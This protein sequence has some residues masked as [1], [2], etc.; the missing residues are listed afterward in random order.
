MLKTNENIKLGESL[1]IFFVR[2]KIDQEKISVAD[3]SDI[4][5]YIEVDGEV[6]SL[7]FD[8]KDNKNKVYIAYKT[9]LIGKDNYYM[10]KD[11]VVLPLESINEFFNISQSENENIQFKNQIIW[12]KKKDYHMLKNKMNFFIDHQELSVKRESWMNWRENNILTIPH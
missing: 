3:F 12:G 1:V 7:F 5:D 4:G 6:V 11:S 8:D 10:N 2:I 9:P